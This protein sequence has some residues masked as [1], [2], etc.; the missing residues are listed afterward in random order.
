LALTLLELSWGH[1]IRAALERFD[2]REAAALRQKNRKSWDAITQL[3]RYTDVVG[4]NIPASA[5]SIQSGELF[6]E[7]PRPSDTP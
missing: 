2:W 1:G 3:I 7:A 4:R 6:V 5:Q